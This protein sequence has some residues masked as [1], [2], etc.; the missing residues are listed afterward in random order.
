MG[1]KKKEGSLGMLHQWSQA[2]VTTLHKAGIKCCVG[3]LGHGIAREDLYFLFDEPSA[4]MGAHRQLAS[5]HGA[6]FFALLPKFQP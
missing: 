6:S 2:S 1:S 4:D 5:S 3:M